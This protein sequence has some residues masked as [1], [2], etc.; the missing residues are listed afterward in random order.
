M[1][2][3]RGFCVCVCVRITV[4]YWWIFED[5]YETLR[6][7][8]LVARDGTVSP[9]HVVI[10]HWTQL[11]VSSPRLTAHVSLLW[12]FNTLLSTPSHSSSNSVIENR[13]LR[14][15]LLLFSALTFCSFSSR[16]L[17]LPAPKFLVNTPL[18]VLLFYVF[19]NVSIYITFANAE[20]R[21]Y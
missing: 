9:R 4:N 2:N 14:V 19:K 12:L 5:L 13:V 17:F 10:L 6:I 7:F 15:L 16:L 20:L 8:W 1:R 11:R 21:K 3:V 18:C